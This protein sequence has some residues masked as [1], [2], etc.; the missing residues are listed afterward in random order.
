[1][2]VMRRLRGLAPDDARA[3]EISPDGLYNIY[4][5]YENYKIIAA[6]TA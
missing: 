5:D 6:A 4:V 3:P 2:F 1:M